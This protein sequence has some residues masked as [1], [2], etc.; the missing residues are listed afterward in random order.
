MGLEH[1]KSVFQDELSLQTDTFTENVRPEWIGEGGYVKRPQALDTLLRGKIY[2]TTNPPTL[3]AEQLFVRGG[4]DNF[5]V[6]NTSQIFDPR[7]EKNSEIIISN[8]NTYTG[9]THKVPNTPF[10]VESFPQTYRPLSELGMDLSQT[11][12]ANLYTSSH[13]SKPFDSK[14]ILAGL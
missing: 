12:W 7:P 9:T 10:G 6:L 1:L 8:K 11:S 3:T 4:N 13:K 14:V 2:S 5:S